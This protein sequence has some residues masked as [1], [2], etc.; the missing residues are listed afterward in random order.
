MNPKMTTPHTP[1]LTCFCWSR[2]AAQVE[3]T[4]KR[5]FAKM[6]NRNCFALLLEINNIVVKVVIDT[7]CL[8]GYCNA[9]KQNIIVYLSVYCAFNLETIRGSHY[10]FVTKSAMENQ[11]CNLHLLWYKNSSRSARVLQ[12]NLNLWKNE[13]HFTDYLV[14]TIS[15]RTD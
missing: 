11:L 3:W 14:C 8:F 1:C 10:E 7:S 2:T 4:W 5:A 12:Q 6:L 9:F 13:I 15:T